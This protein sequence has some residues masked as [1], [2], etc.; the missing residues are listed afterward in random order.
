ME[1]TRFVNKVPECFNCSICLGIVKEPVEHNSCQTIFCSE[2]IKELKKCPHCRETI[3]LRSNFGKVNRHLMQQYNQLIIHCVH[4]PLCQQITPLENLPQHEEQ[5]EYVEMSCSQFGCKYRC[6]KIELPKHE[7]ECPRRKLSCPHCK[8]P[9]IYAFNMEN[10]LLKCTSIPKHLQRNN[11]SASKSSSVSKKS[12]AS[13]PT[14]GSLPHNSKTTPPMFPTALNTSATTAGVTNPP[15]T[16]NSSLGANI[17]TMPT[18]SVFGE[19]SDDDNINT[20]LSAEEW[21]SIMT[22]L[23]SPATET[24]ASRR[25]ITAP[26]TNNASQ[27]LPPPGP[28]TTRASTAG[29][30]SNTRTAPPIPRPF[31]PP[32]PSLDFYQQQQVMMVQQNMQQQQQQ[33]AYIHAAY[34]YPNPSLMMMHPFGPSSAAY[35]PPSLYHPAM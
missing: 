25:T 10:H 9:F 13:P 8:N 29:T 34:G 23:H 3:G 32:A 24:T 19:D 6:A 21:D 11:A 2:C 27:R 15:I 18:F 1:E 4:F 16:T 7:Q 31:L 26:A 22:G 28:S 17:R 33:A 20:E 12:V 5:C 14:T 35:W 30:G